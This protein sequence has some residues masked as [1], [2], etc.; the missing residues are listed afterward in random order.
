VEV[1]TLAALDAALEAGADA[2][3]LDNFDLDGLRACVTK[4]RAFDAAHG[5]RT[6]L[7]ASGNMTLDR[8]RAVAE[9]GVDLISVGALTHSVCAFDVSLRLEGAETPDQPD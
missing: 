3:L 2:V 5:R 6:L 1:E 9:T 7:E 4:A 8:V